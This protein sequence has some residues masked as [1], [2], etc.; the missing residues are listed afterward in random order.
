MANEEILGGLRIALEKGQK[1]RTAMMSFYNSGYTKEEIEDAARALIQIEK[2]EQSRQALMAQQQKTKKPGR[3]QAK[4]QTSSMIKTQGTTSQV[5]QTRATQPIQATTLPTQRQIVSN[6]EPK[7]KSGKIIVLAI[8]LG[9][10]LISLVI[11]FLF[12]DNI[13]D[14]FNP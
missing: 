8:V 3:A 7:K 11:V 4:V 1:L 6:Y 9:I 12:R 2:E 5:P 14:F 13:I 10:L